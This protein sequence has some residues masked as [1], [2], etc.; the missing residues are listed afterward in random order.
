LKRPEVALTGMLAMGPFI[1]IA[2]T[3]LPLFLY[4]LRN[5]G[6]TVSKS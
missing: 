1:L 2:L 4:K 6:A 3:N 5:L